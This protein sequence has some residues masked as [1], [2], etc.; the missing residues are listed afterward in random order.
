M[1]ASYDTPPRITSIPTPPITPIKVSLPIQISLDALCEPFKGLSHED[2][3]RAILQILRNARIS[4]LQLVADLA[5]VDNLDGAE[6]RSKWY[7][8]DALGLPNLLDSIMGDLTGATKLR[9]WAKPR[10]GDL[11]DVVL[12]EEIEAA[13][14]HLSLEDGLKG[15]TPEFIGSWSAHT[16]LHPLR[17]LCPQISRIAIR[18]AQTDRAKRK[19]KVKVPDTV[20]VL[21][22]KWSPSSL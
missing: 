13:C 3:K 2:Q 4:P 8:A 22:L 1:T 18:A 20:S 12:E 11:I 14:G 15:I 6:F 10:I 17:T 21:L 5:D 9:S 16:I 7:Q 19:N